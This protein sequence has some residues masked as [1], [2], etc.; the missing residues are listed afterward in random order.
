MF[1]SLLQFPSPLLSS[2]FPSF[3]PW[4][5]LGSICALELRQIVDMDPMQS[6]RIYHCK[7]EW[8]VNNWREKS[9]L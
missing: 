1:Y 2:V 7:D 3:I 9:E 4:L 5:V 8:F 6:S